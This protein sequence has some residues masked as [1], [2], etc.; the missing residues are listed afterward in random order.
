MFLESQCFWKGGSLG[1]LI[2][3]KPDTFRNSVPMG[4]LI[5]LE[6]L[7]FCNIVSFDNRILFAI[8]ILLETRWF[9]IFGTFKTR[10]FENGAFY[11]YFCK[12]DI[13]DSSTLN[14]LYVE[15]RD[16]CE[17]DN[18]RNSI[19]LKVWLFANPT[20]MQTLHLKKYLKTHSSLKIYRHWNSILLDFYT[21]GTQYFGELDNF[22]S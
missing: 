20:L 18:F 13:L 4:N 6:T 5:L 7:Y 14:S 15:T 9:R 2:L 10:N 1:N 16:F 19:H 11:Q 12:L 3:W 17:L 8:L 22:V 21:H